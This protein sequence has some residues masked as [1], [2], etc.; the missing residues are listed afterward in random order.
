MC[1]NALIFNRIGDEVWRYTFRYFNAVEEM[2][3]S[4]LH[5]T[6]LT[7]YGLEALEI[8]NKA[9]SSM[10]ALFEV[11]SARGS[12]KK[13]KSGVVVLDSIKESDKKTVKKV[14]T[15]NG[16][17]NTISEEMTDV[18][19]LCGEDVELR[20]DNEE[21]LESSE[22]GEPDDRPEE[23]PVV[24]IQLQPLHEPSSFIQPFFTMQS[25][26]DAFYSVALDACLVCGSSGASSHFLF[27]FD[28]GEAFHDFCCNAPRSMSDDARRSW[29]CPNCKICVI[30]GLVSEGDGE[31]ML[32]CEACDDAFHISCLQPTLPTVDNG[33][34]HNTWYCSQCVVCACCS[35]RKVK[36]RG[37]EESSYQTNSPMS[38]GY[39]ANLCYPCSLLSST[40][41]RSRRQCH[42]LCDFPESV[43]V[44]ECSE[45]DKIFHFEC[46]NDETKNWKFNEFYRYPLCKGCYSLKL[47]HNSQFDRKLQLAEEISEIQFQRK[48]K[49]ENQESQMESLL[50]SSLDQMISEN[51]Y[52]CL[53]MT[54]WGGVRKLLFEE[55][56]RC[57]ESVVNHRSMILPDSNLVFMPAKAR[58]YVNYMRR[59]KSHANRHIP[60]PSRETTLSPQALL[61]LANLSSYFTFVSDLEGVNLRHG[62]TEIVIVIFEVGLL[63]FKKY[64]SVLSTLNAEPTGE[65]NNTAVEEN[66]VVL[67][68][69]NI[70]LKIYTS[71]G[72]PQTSVLSAGRPYSKFGHFVPSRNESGRSERD[73]ATVEGNLR[74]AMRSLQLLYP[75]DVHV[76]ESYV[77]E[78]FKELSQ[79]EKLD[80]SSFFNLMFGR[81]ALPTAEK[82]DGKTMHKMLERFQAARKNL[83]CKSANIYVAPPSP[84]VTQDVKEFRPLVGKI[85]RDKSKGQS[86]LH[87]SGHTSSLNLKE[88]GVL[89]S[90]SPSIS[91]ISS[92]QRL[93]KILAEVKDQLTRD[94]DI[95]D[96]TTIIDTLNLDS[97]FRDYCDQYLG[98]EETVHVIDLPSAGKYSSE[99]L[100][101]QSSNSRAERM[102]GWK[103]EEPQSLSIAS[104]AKQ[105]KWMD[106][107][108][109]LFC[110][111]QSEDDLHGRLLPF[112]D[113]ALAHANCLLW[114]SEVEV[115]GGQ[116]VNAE[117]A[118]LR[119]SQQTCY[120]CLKRGATIGCCRGNGLRRCKRT[121]HLQCAISSKC[122]LLRM[123]PTHR[124]RQVADPTSFEAQETINPKTAEFV[125]I[126][127]EH[128][129][130]KRTLV[131]EDQYDVWVAEDPDRCLVVET[132]DTR[133]EMENIAKVLAQQRTDIAVKSGAVTI[134][135][136][137]SPAIDKPYFSNK[138]VLYPHHF[139][140]TRI[141]WSMISANHRTVYFFEVLDRSDIEQWDASQMS[142]LRRSLLKLQL[143]DTERLECDDLLAGPIFRVVALDCMDSPIFGKTVSQL[144]RH[145]LHRVAEVNQSSHLARKV[146]QSY[147]SYNLTPHQFFGLGLPCVTEAIELIP[148]SI[149]SMINLSTADRY[150]PYYHLP[151][152]K[153][154]QNIVKYLSSL[155]SSTQSHSLN[156]STR[157]DPYLSR[158]SHENVAVRISSAKTAGTDPLCG[159]AS[160][161]G[162]DT[163]DSDE[164]FV[165]LNKENSKAEIENRKIR[166]LDM[167]RSYLR[168][169]YAKLEVKKSR[170]HGWGLFSKINYEKDDVIVEY[171]GEKIRQPIA[172][173]RELNYELEGVGSCYLFR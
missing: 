76:V 10:P 4:N 91:D 162:A 1:C 104:V 47:P 41:Q 159:E 52:T 64:F 60:S 13:R 157:A 33:R 173:R 170:I 143:F 84:S 155:Q 21:D 61:T 43:P 100:L 134:L 88:G 29:R 152:H 164:Y 48:R 35:L 105:Q 53:I 3:N 101:T 171:I 165:D 58:R 95:P 26:E 65:G 129:I 74:Q 103:V 98:C 81:W 97:I 92:G 151:S 25:T 40:E 62:L 87:L 169:P 106:Y 66:A 16:E 24:S 36:P 137:G 167:T 93:L 110:M 5:R 50:Q 79:Q 34:Q 8:I 11:Q 147:H 102:I 108:C 57:T 18:A 166:F 163:A 54:I 90:G 172:D 142:Y 72:I 30:C 154:I 109:C 132:C 2:F 115:V 127:P 78:N 38:W 141:F 116:V 39:L 126:C 131:V 153:E 20:S 148:S 51:V 114:C 68:L 55:N 67:R 7:A 113:G 37:R 63:L 6:Q 117:D 83:I 32:L 28:C 59:H 146:R 160:S 122:L 94:Y 71:I 149:L 135:K 136:I 80:V 119:C 77:V 86:L 144:H 158:S 125:A 12:G 31:N 124:S 89:I 140:S 138:H 9:K 118:R 133:L 23:L 46:A 14:K 85:L 121:Y 75:A 168:N 49:I 161:G 123:N 82:E 99:G 96:A 69:E 27:C 22:P 139:T 73:M 17:E 130:E 45:C 120:F 111:K 42:Y 44:F 56:K 107:R 150:C 15:H 70:I 19:E 156:G 145:V 112:P 128:L